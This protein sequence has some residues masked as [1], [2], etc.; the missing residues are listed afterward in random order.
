VLSHHSLQSINLFQSSHS[1]FSRYC[2]SSISEWRSEI[3]VSSDRRPSLLLYPC[4]LWHSTSRD[5]P[6]PPADVPRATSSD[7]ELSPFASRFR[8]PV[9]HLPRPLLTFSI[10]PSAVF[11]FTHLG[12][13]S[14]TFPSAQ[15][16]QFGHRRSFTLHELSRSIPR[17]SFIFLDLLR[18]FNPR[19]S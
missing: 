9:I 11:D 10:P 2:G 16:R 3:K 15:F 5:L 7:F 17:C 1:L 6:A 8:D 19:H 13:A 4:L 18:L 12:S 14:S